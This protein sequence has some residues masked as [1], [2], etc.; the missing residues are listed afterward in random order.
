MAV[1]GLRQEVWPA[2][3]LTECV[4]VGDLWPKLSYSEYACAQV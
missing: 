3:R 4:V 2:F 1:E